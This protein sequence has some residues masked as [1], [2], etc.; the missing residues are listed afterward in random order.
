[1]FWFFISSSFISYSI[2]QTRTL[3]AIKEVYKNYNIIL[4]PHTAIGYAASSDYLKC[5]K[6]SI[7]VTLATAHP[8]KFSNAVQNAIGKEPSLPAKYKNIFELDEK[9]E[10]LENDYEIVKDFILKNTLN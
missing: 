10:V 2:N 5:N 4:D 3:E 9:Y 8:I 1:M 6:E 7:A